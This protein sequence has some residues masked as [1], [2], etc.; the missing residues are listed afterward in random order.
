MI[1][2]HIIHLTSLPRLENDK[3]NRIALREM[4]LP[5]QSR[6]QAEAELTA[7]LATGDDEKGEELLTFL[8]SLGFERLLSSQ[9]LRKQRL[10]D[11][12][13]VLAMMNV[14][15]FH[16]FWCVLIEPRTY[17][18]SGSQ[19]STVPMQ[20][21]QVSKWLL[22]TYRLATQDWAYGI[23]AFAAA[24]TSSATEGFTSRDAAI[25]VL[26]FYTGPCRACV[27]VSVSVRTSAWLRQW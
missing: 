17:H 14:I 26:Y 13:S 18:F 8:D 23:F 2:V 15:L 10:C 25:F 1:P 6:A 7:K 3:I 4:T 5:L 12:L 11:N 9:Q 21:L 24:Q 19:S 16:W 22:Y 27:T 20:R